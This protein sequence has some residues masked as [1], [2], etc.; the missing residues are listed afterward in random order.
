MLSGTVAQQ[1][2]SVG[3]TA[4]GAIVSSGIAS[5]F[6]LSTLAIPIVGAAI[7]GVTFAILA[8]LNRKRPK[9]KTAT[10]QIAN[11]TEQHMVA[12]LRAWEASEKTVADQEQALLNFDQL[13]G[14]MVAEVSQEAYGP[15]GEW[16]VTDRAREPISGDKLPGVDW[17]Q[18][19]RDPIAYDRNTQTGL[20]ENIGA[21]FGMGTSFG[22]FAVVGGLALL[23][24]MM[25][26][27]D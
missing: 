6:A 18:L 20:L 26:T 12:N 24:L 23:G 2:I 19:Y 25:F 1:G 7:A 5:G 16:T 11:E 4:G 14:A 17:F 15:P 22:T 27:G 9:Q 3:A 10:T 13:W 8:F 21:S